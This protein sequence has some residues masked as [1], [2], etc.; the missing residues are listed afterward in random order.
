MARRGCV[1]PLLSSTNLHGGLRKKAQV[2]EAQDFAD[3]VKTENEARIE[4]GMEFAKQKRQETMDFA[5]E[6]KASKMESKKEVKD[7]AKAKVKET[8]EKLGLK[9]KRDRSALQL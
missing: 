1:S 2:Q 9:K 8:K 6:L 5:Q 7:F 4:K 3:T